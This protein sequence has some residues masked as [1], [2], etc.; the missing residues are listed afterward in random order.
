GRRG[1]RGTLHDRRNIHYNRPF[2]SARPTLKS[3]RGAP[4]TPASRLGNTRTPMRSSSASKY[5]VTGIDHTGSAPMGLPRQ[6]PNTSTPAST[7]DHTVLVRFQCRAGPTAQRYRST[8]L[9]GS[10]VRCSGT[11]SS[12]S[13]HG[14]LRCSVGRYPSSNPRLFVLTLTWS[15]RSVARYALP[16]PWGTG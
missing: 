7:P 2:T 8:S 16:A 14:L 4:C 6:R 9:A 12:A 15:G 3:A 1:V 13:A 10:P 11:A 5:Q